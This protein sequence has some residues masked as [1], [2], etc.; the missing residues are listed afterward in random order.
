MNLEVVKGYSKIMGLFDLIEFCFDGQ[1]VIDV[2]KILPVNALEDLEQVLTI[3]PT[4]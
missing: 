1:K 2:A 3:K 4:F